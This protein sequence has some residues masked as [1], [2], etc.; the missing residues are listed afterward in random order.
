VGVEEKEKWVVSGFPKRGWSGVERS[1]VEWRGVEWRRREE[2]VMFGRGWSGVE[3]RRREEKSLFWFP[4]T[5][6][7]GTARVFFYY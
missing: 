6:H 7:T 2:S 5:L 3:W 4:K 1:G